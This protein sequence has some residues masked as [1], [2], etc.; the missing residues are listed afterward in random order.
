MSGHHFSFKLREQLHT[1][2]LL[3]IL[4]YFSNDFIWFHHIPDLCHEFLFFQ[5]LN[6]EPC[7]QGVTICAKTQTVNPSYLYIN[8]YIDIYILID[9]INPRKTIPAE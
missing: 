6:P 7:L 2:Y 1:Q 8:I 9:Y 5:P 4:F 3:R